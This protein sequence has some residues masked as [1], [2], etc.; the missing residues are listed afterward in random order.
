MYVEK[1]EN[2]KAASESGKN[3]DE[4]KKAQTEEPPETPRCT[5]RSETKGGKAL[6]G[7]NDKTPGKEVDVNDEEKD[8][9]SEHADAEE[10]KYEV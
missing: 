5:R 1:M 10:P 2:E 9:E 6:K 8:N 3:G 7:T 4:G